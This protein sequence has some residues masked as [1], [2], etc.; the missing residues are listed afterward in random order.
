M[1]TIYVCCV[2]LFTHEIPGGAPKPFQQF[3]SYSNLFAFYSPTSWIK[4]G[5]DRYFQK[6]VLT[7]VTKVGWP[8]SC[9]LGAQLRTWRRMKTDGRRAIKKRTIDIVVLFGQWIEDHPHRATERSIPCIELKLQHM[10]R[11]GYGTVKYY[12]RHC[13]QHV[14]QRQMEHTCR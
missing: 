5:W 9:V 4:M 8:L 3:Q 11:V 2:E 7:S 10:L 1:T 14:S 13:Q 12:Q 6:N